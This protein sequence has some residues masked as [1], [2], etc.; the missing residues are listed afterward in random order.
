MSSAYARELKNYEIEF[1]IKNQ[2]ERNARLAYIAKNTGTI[3]AQALRALHE[4]QEGVPA[5]SDEDAFSSLSEKKIEELTRSGREYAGLDLDRQFD[6]EGRRPRQMED[7]CRAMVSLGMS[8]DD[9]N[10]VE[11]FLSKVTSTDL[12]IE[13]YLEALGVDGVAAYRAVESLKDIKA[14][15]ENQPE[16]Y[17]EFLIKEIEA[18]S[19]RVD[20]NILQNISDVKTIIKNLEV[21]SKDHYEPEAQKRI[22]KLRFGLAR[23]LFIQGQRDLSQSFVNEIPVSYAEIHDEFKRIKLLDKASGGKLGWRQKFSARRTA[24]SSIEDTRNGLRFGE[25]P[26]MMFTIDEDK[27]AAWLALAISGDNKK[28]NFHVGRGRS[29]LGLGRFA[30][31]WKKLTAE[32]ILEQV[33]WSVTRSSDEGTLKYYDKYLPKLRAETRPL[34]HQAVIDLIRAGDHEAA[35]VVLTELINDERELRFR[36][37]LGAAA[38]AGVYRDRPDGFTDSVARIAANIELFDDATLPGLKVKISDMITRV[39][40]DT[41]QAERV[42][43]IRQLISGLPDKSL[44]IHYHE[45]LQQILSTDKPLAIHP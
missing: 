13:V 2:G 44:Q 6:I 19:D 8:L 35:D 43:E 37:I 29:E 14:E 26:D 10:I 30:G 36:K 42:Q 33:S 20:V 16:Q 5:P 7:V 28:Y 17:V 4:L 1:I 32:Q 23:A 18:S 34:K 38:M 11:F 45:Q 31:E 27:A 39:S 41:D 12:K 9:S 40:L 24:K 25:I 21:R 15:L 3:T 22:A